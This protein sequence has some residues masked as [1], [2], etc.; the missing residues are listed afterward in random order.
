MLIN[1]HLHPR[2]LF[3]PLPNPCFIPLT[4]PEETRSTVPKSP[5]LT[6]EDVENLIDCAGT[7]IAY[8]AASGELDK[9]NQTYRVIESSLEL[10]DGE[11]P[12]DKTL[13]YA[14]IRKAFALLASRN[15]FPDWQMREIADNDLA[16]D[17]TTADM[18]I[19]QAM[20]DEIPFG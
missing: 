17:A 20:F 2:L 15:A 8:W 4:H 18:T 19:Q 7:G 9:E 12:A 6:D 16:F 13:T 14:Q 5:T 10:A 1:E 11:E 3:P